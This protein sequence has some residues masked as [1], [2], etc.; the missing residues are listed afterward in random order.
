[1]AL[2]TRLMIEVEGDRLLQHHGQDSHLVLPQLNLCSFFHLRKISNSRRIASTC[3]LSASC[4]ASRICNSESWW[5]FFSGVGSFSTSTFFTLGFGTVAAN[6]SA[7]WRFDSGGVLV[8]FITLTWAV[9]QLRTMRPNS[10]IRSSFSL[11]IHN[12]NKRISLS[13]THQLVA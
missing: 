13:W 1:M 12:K 4:F 3:C 8:L 2:S 7:F 9:L 5:W 10:F 11:W 6:S